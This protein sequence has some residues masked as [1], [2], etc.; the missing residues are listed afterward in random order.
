MVRHVARVRGAPPSYQEE[1]QPREV[2]VAKFALSSATLHRCYA[3]DVPS[4]PLRAL[5]S[6][7]FEKPGSPRPEEAMVASW[8]TRVEGRC[9]TPHCR[10]YSARRLSPLTSTPTAA[11]R[12]VARS[13][14]LS[15]TSLEPRKRASCHEALVDVGRGTSW[16]RAGSLTKRPR[17]TPP[18]TRLFWVTVTA[19]CA[20]N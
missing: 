1:P 13:H 8:L 20:Q 17:R 9:S 14:G 19:L 3:A 7:P 6:R 12:E 16:A 10:A 2:Q 15:S 5:A 11:Y 18:S 4:S